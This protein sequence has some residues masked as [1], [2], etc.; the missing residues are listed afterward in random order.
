MDIAIY[1][2]DTGS[3]PA[4][5]WWLSQETNIGPEVY[6]FNTGYCTPSG[7]HVGAIVIE[8]EQSKYHPNCKNSKN[9]CFVYTFQK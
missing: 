6:D 4:I 5:H 1:Q 3:A 2:N 9:T 7:H 8:N